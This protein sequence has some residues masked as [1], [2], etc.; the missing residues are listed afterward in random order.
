[1]VVAKYSKRQSSAD[2]ADERS[3]CSMTEAVPWFVPISIIL[4]FAIW[5]I[6]EVCFKE[7]TEPSKPE[8]QTK[9]DRKL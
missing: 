7:I 4:V 2:I 1:M 8:E 5:M 6:Y 3:R 9:V